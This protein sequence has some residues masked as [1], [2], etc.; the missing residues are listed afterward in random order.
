MNAN[1]ENNEKTKKVKITVTRTFGT[2]C[3]LEIYTDYVA[4]KIKDN[5]RKEG[6][7]KD[8]KDPKKIICTFDVFKLRLYNKS[9]TIALL[10]KRGK[11]EE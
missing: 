10:G 5:L 2:H 4:K 8:E 11:N 6:G 7:K 9:T 1:I 3:L